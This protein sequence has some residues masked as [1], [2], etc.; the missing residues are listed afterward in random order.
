MKPA[1][2]LPFCLLL[3]ALPAHAQQVGIENPDVS[4]PTSLY[5][6]VIDIQDMPINTQ[7]PDPA[8]SASQGYGPGTAT[9]KCLHPYTGDVTGQ[10]HGTGGTTSQILHTAYG[11]S[12]PSY[13]EYDFLSANGQPRIHQERG[14]S[15]DAIFDQSYPFV[16]DWYVA[17]FNGYGAENDQVP[18]PTPGVVIAATMRA[19]DSISVDDVAYDSGPVLA[20]G[21]T[22]PATLVPSPAPGTGGA[23]DMM[24]GAHEQVTYEGFVG[25]KHVFHFRVPMTYEAD[26]IQRAT[27]YNVRIDMY[28]DNPACQEPTD[29]GKE[30]LMPST[31]A[32]Y[33]SA[34][35][36]PRLDLAIMNPIRV[37][38]LHPQFIGDELVIHAAVNS[39]WGNYDVQEKTED[40]IRI[41][42]TG[43]QPVRSLAQ[44]A[45]SQRYHDHYHHQEA[46]DL[47]YIW[48]YQADGVEDGTYFVHLKFTNDQGT[49]VAS[50]T[51]QFTVG[52]DVVGCG[53]VQEATQTLTQE[54][55]KTPNTLTGGAAESPGAPLALAV[56]ALGAVAA[57][58]RR[59][60]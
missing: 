56:A 22:D 50:A 38:Y 20:A 24:G 1:L 21:K 44:A 5:F 6:H 14:I 57:L 54:C 55:S 8:F 59:R 45:F 42:V 48:D 49:A 31:L 32:A 19:G 41:E 47:A 16:L 11:Y 39:A 26:R 34:D 58:L 29:I 10:G 53:D 17:V 23:F 18:T 9:L 40:G 7:E 2:L 28:V 3:V 15:Y 27:G 51:A 43:P 46:V 25:G 13:V 36:R 35:H 52:G 37:E 12:S 33:S 60:A 30:Y 4:T